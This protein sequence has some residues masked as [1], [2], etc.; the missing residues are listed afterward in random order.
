MK[1]KKKQERWKLT[2]DERGPRM[3]TQELRLG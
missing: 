1:N 2:A 3:A